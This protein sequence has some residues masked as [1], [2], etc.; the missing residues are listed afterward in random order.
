MPNAQLAQQLKD[1]EHQLASARRAAHQEAADVVPAVLQQLL[2][3]GPAQLAQVPGSSLLLTFSL[4]W[5]EV[6]SVGGSGHLLYISKHN[7]VAKLQMIYISFL[8]LAR[9]RQLRSEPPPGL[10]GLRLPLH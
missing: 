2:C 1:T 10:A 3:L 9:P 4:G 5:V 7:K 6:E 8:R